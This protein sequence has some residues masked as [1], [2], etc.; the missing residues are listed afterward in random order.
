MRA[1]TDPARI[2]QPI[3]VETSTRFCFGQA[4][5]E[6]VA[7]F[8]KEGTAFAEEDLKA[9]E[10]QCPRIRLYLTKRDIFGFLQIMV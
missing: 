1:S 4:V 8:D 6:N 5:I 2:E 10:V 7:V 9:V 3:A